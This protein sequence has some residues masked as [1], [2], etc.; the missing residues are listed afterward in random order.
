MTLEDLL[1]EPQQTPDQLAL[2]HQQ[3]MEQ[4]YR[5]QI[6]LEKQRQAKEALLKA[7]EEKSAV[8]TAQAELHEKPPV[9]EPEEVKREA[10]PEPE[11]TTPEVKSEE[12]EPVPE[13][14]LEPV[15]EPAP[16]P[17]SQPEGRGGIPTEPNEVV[18]SA[19]QLAA[20][21]NTLK[22]LTEEVAELKAGKTQQ[23][24]TV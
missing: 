24:N 3:Q 17:T 22:Q 14:V 9:Q 5:L 8:K 6:V 19:T 1:K 2:Q 13:P 11:A 23:S 16:E 7:E 4:L 20:L 18:L 15:P 21:M 12:P 10:P